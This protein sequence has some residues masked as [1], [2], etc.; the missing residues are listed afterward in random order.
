MADASPGLIQDKLRLREQIY[1][2]FVDPPYFT[3]KQKLL[4]VPGNIEHATMGTVFLHRL[5]NYM[6]LSECE[7]TVNGNF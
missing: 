5:D 1:N 6:T 2:F 7:V 4:F 3:L